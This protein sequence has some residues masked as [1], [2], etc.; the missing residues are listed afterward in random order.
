MGDI[1]DH[2]RLADACDR[3]EMARVVISYEDHPRLDELYPSS[4]WTKLV[5]ER[6]KNLSCA[7][8]TNDRMAE[9]LLIN[10]DAREVVR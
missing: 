10:G 8:G 5:I 3:F 9:V 1:D 2:A 6:P 7:T 4:R